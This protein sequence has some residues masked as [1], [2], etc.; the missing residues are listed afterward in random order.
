MD[1]VK[2]TRQQVPVLVAADMN[3]DKRDALNVNYSL[4]GMACGALAVD[5]CLEQNLEQKN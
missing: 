5:V 2:N 4:T 1:L 3:W